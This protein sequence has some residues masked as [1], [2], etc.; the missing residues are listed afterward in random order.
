M[1]QCIEELDTTTASHRIFPWLQALLLVQ[2][3][4]AG[5][6]VNGDGDAG[7]PAPTDATI[8]SAIQ[9]IADVPFPLLGNPAISPFYGE[10]HL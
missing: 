6:R 3:I 2:A 10:L 5:A 1:P 4:S 7:E 8:N 9:L